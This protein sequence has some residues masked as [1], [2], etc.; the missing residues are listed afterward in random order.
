MLYELSIAMLKS[1]NAPIAI[2]RQ[3]HDFQKRA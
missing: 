3:G 2:L 1:Y